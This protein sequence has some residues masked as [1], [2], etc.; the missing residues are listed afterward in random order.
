MGFPSFRA[1]HGMHL[2]AMLETRCA[3]LLP[4]WSKIKIFILLHQRAAHY[5]TKYNKRWLVCQRQLDFLLTKLLCVLHGQAWSAIVYQLIPNVQHIEQ[6]LATFINLL[7]A[8]EVLLFEKATFLVSIGCSRGFL[9]GEVTPLGNFPCQ[10][11]IW[12]V[13]ENQTW[14]M[15]N[16]C[17]IQKSRFQKLYWLWTWQFGTSW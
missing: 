7:D 15:L 6:S 8:D 13:W 1:S 17:W 4:S 16:L 11:E 10:G 5:K 9:I 12:F 2:Y 3:S 14:Q